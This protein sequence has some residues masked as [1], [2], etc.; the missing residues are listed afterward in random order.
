MEPSITGTFDKWNLFSGPPGPN[1][2][3]VTGTFA[4]SSK[5]VI[6]ADDDDEIGAYET[7][8]DECLQKPTKAD[9]RK[10]IPNGFEAIC[11]IRLYTSLIY[12][13]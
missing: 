8:D 4:K 2:P 9:V 11:G 13:S 12:L 1:Y 5:D 3:L 7:D 10:A 6:S